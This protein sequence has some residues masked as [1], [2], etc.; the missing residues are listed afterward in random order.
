MT[1]AIKEKAQDKVENPQENQAEQFLSW[2]KEKR[3]FRIRCNN[4]RRNINTPDPK[5][6][7][8]ANPTM[9][10][11]FVNVRRGKQKSWQ[12]Q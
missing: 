10:I 11:N 3:T 2:T 4:K 8:W 9:K 6:I 7:S 1:L 5:K 12:A